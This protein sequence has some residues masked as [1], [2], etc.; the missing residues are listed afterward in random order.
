M[1]TFIGNASLKYH[2]NFRKACNSGCELLPFLSPE[3]INTFDFSASIRLLPIESR[4]QS[5]KKRRRRRAQLERSDATSV[6]FN[7]S[8]CDYQLQRQSWGVSGFHGSLEKMAAL[9]QSAINRYV[10][11]REE[12]YCDFKG[13]LSKAKSGRNKKTKHHSEERL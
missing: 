6:F 8:S 4:G 3:Q 7:H 9:L 13:N 2:L 11:L 12:S 1:Q 5:S 10:F